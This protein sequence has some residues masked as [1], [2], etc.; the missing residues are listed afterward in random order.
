M[1]HMAGTHILQR[2]WHSSALRPITLIFLAQLKQMIRSLLSGGVTCYK[3]QGA[4]P[5]NPCEMMSIAG[6]GQAAA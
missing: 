1:A 4:V 6:T 3:R 2:G 5:M